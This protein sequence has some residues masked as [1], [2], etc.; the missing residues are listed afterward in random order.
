[1]Y[2]RALVAVAA[3]ILSSPSLGCAAK[4]QPK[5]TIPEGVEYVIPHSCI[6]SDVRCVRDGDRD[7]CHFEEFKNCVQVHV[8]K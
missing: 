3:A 1:M 6:V 8:K 5:A 4:K 7:V 2:K